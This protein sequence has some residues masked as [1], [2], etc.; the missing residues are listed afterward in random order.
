MKLILTDDDGKVVCRWRIIENTEGM[1][2]SLRPIP[3]HI[4]KIFDWLGSNLD[5]MREE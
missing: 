5:L 3:F 4:E 1:P 2:C